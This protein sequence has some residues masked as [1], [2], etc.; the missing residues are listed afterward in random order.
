MPQVPLT[1]KA[2]AESEVKLASKLGVVQKKLSNGTWEII[3]KVVVEA[4]LVVVVV[5]IVVTSS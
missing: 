2:A 3:E 4:A 1:G 5:V